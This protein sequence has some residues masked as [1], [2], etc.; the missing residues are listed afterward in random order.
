MTYLYVFLGLQIALVFYF[1]IIK[2]E[3]ESKDVELWASKSFFSAVWVASTL[4]LMSEK[5][6]N[7]SYDFFDSLFFAIF[8]PF[9]LIFQYGIWGGA[10]LLFIL[11]MIVLMV[12]LFPLAYFKNRKEPNEK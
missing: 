5:N 3:L 1:V 2:K 7:R 12:L 8:S 6:G 10:Y 11:G 9:Y 4:Y